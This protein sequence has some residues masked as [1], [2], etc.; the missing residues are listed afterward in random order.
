MFSINI[1]VVCAGIRKRLDV[2]G[3][4]FLVNAS[5]KFKI[6]DK[7]KCFRCSLRGLILRDLKAREFLFHVMKT[8][9]NFLTS[10]YLFHSNLL[11]RSLI[12][13]QWPS[14]AWWMLICSARY[15]QPLLSH[16]IA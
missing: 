16:M 5:F 10:N 11:K 13:C 1:H 12:A 14:N 7:I 6:E 9:I 15:N 3:Y 2:S 4:L 8:S